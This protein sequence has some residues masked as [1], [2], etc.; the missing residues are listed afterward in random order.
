MPQPRAH[1][2]RRVW[3]PAGFFGVCALVLFA[4]LI[5]VQVLEHGHYANIAEAE[6]GASEQLFGR[7][8]SILDRN[9][10][11]LATSIDTW[12][13]YVSAQAWK[14]PQKALRSSE[15]LGKELK[16]D[17]AVL[18]ER[19]RDKAYGDIRIRADLDYE[20]G[21]ALQKQKIDGLVAVPN[22][23]RV[24]PD[25]DVGASV[26]GFIGDDNDGRS[27]IEA[28]LN[29]TLTGKPGKI[30]YERTTAGAPIPFGQSIVDPAEEGK[31]VV[32]TIDRYIQQL[33]EQRLAQAVT[34]HRAKG[35]SIVIMD[36]RT[37]AIL[38]LATTPG[39]K[40]SQL[41]ISDPKQIELLKNRSVTETY[42][43]G[44]VMKAITAA[45]AI[46]AGV[47]TP[48]TGY[49]DVGYVKQYD[50]EIK[51]F[52]GESWGNQ[53]MTGVLQHSI[54]TGAIFMARLL[55]KEKFGAYQEAFGFGKPT[56]V[57]LSGESGGFY[58][59]YTD[60]NWTIA[61]FWTQSFGQGINVTVLQMTSAFT[62]VINGGTLL[63]PHLVKSYVGEDGRRQEVGRD[64]VG[65]PIS[66]ATSATLRQML[67][68]VIMPPE[69][70]HPGKPRDYTA[71]GKSGTADIE[72]INGL[73]SGKLIVSF[74]G[75]APAVDPQIVVY[76]MLDEN[77][78][79]KT[80]A[81][82]A[83]PVFSK[84]V[85]D[86]LHYLNVTPDGARYVGAR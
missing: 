62:A 37:G 2:T 50:V 61:D 78:D 76:V 54:N 69:I 38:A 12:D 77:A 30:I 19:V 13:I 52:K 75:F 20:A 43:P 56:G 45:A 59:H 67:Q 68:D 33:A 28:A 9:G 32:L 8:G 72:A 81:E 6:L 42:Q 14:D 26:L 21:I 5:Q 49:T 48:N 46:D 7:R 80:G 70:G 25:G 41:P 64:A 66:A 47:V 44:S 83:A 31:D 73:P 27:G 22:T 55:G 60:K 58:N 53:T 85:D 29:D 18:R 15:A 65:Q 86:T 57:E 39:L 36:P 24:N 10:N 40:F 84:L 16:L 71:G 51:N 74:I 3:V 11:V 79:G 17:P 4:R 63:K 23:A 82:A 34:E 1:Q 35:G